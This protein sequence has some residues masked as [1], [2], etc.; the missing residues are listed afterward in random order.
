MQAGVHLAVCRLA[1]PC[2][3][4]CTVDGTIVM[5][6]TPSPGSMLY[7]PQLNVKIIAIHFTV[8]ATHDVN[9]EA[10]SKRSEMLNG[11]EC[12]GNNSVQ[13]VR[14]KKIDRIDSIKRKV[15]DASLY[16]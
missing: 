15:A 11:L 5:V 7:L 6:A 2:L 14:G 12:V 4:Y 9:S 1:R 3:D 16:L 10:Y 13:V 8:T